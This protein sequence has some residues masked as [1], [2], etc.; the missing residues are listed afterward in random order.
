MITHLLED[1]RRRLLFFLVYQEDQEK[2]KAAADKRN[3]VK[4]LGLFFFCFFL[5]KDPKATVTVIG[6]DIQRT[7]EIC[8]I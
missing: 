2:K 3:I 7:V 4:P 6:N 8:N 5:K 1:I